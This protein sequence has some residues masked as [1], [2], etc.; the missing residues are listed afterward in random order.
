[1][2]FRKIL[3]KVSVWLNFSKPKRARKAKR[4]LL[5]RK[6]KK[7]KKNFKAK[8]GFFV[9]LEYIMADLNL[10]TKEVKDLTRIERIGAH[11]HIRGKW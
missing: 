8:N 2:N 7:S 9:Y 6:K 3:K 10:G 5:N 4:K 11:S 1:M